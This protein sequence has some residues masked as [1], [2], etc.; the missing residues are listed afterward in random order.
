M[1]RRRMLHAF[2]TELGEYEDAAVLPAET[3]PQ[4]YLSRNRQPQPFHLICSKDNVLSQLSGAVH[5]H[6]RDSSVNRFRMDV[7]DHIYIPAGTP[8]RIVPID[9]GV[10]LRYQPLEAGL[11]GAAWYCDGCDSELR[12]YEWEYDSDT[13]AAEFYAAACARFSA[14]EAARTCGKCG[15]VAAPLD[16]A[17]FGWSLTGA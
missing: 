4:L 6:L 8:H 16:L 2:K 10:T 15:T 12:R 9:E 14:E 17:A 7:G 3:D 13:P 5:V 1:N 11:Q